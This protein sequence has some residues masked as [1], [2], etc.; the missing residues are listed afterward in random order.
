VSASPA[1]RLSAL[2]SAGLELCWLYTWADFLTF[3]FLDRPF[4][5]PHAL[6]AFFGGALIA[7]A[8]A[9]LT[10]R[11]LPRLG[12]HTA[13][14]LA[15]ALGTAYYFHG[16]D[17]G[18]SGFQWLSDL[19]SGP[20]PVVAG[21]YLALETIL[22]G[23]LYFV[24]R[25]WAKRENN[26]RSMANLFDLG[27]S[28]FVAMYLIRFF[29]ELKFGVQI[30]NPAG[31]RLPIAFFSFGLLGLAMA[32]TRG[33]AVQ[34]FKPRYKG[35]WSVLTFT[36]AA[37]LLGLGLVA[38]FFSGLT[39]AADV[40][41]EVVKTAARPLQPILIAVLRFMFGANR[42]EAAPQDPPSSVAIEDGISLSPPG[43]WEGTAAQI[44]G[45]IGAI[46]LA[47]LVAATGLYL[48][49][50]LLRHLLAEQGDPAP[51]LNV[52]D[53]FIRLLAR[54]LALVRGLFQ[55]PSPRPAEPLAAYLSLL[56]WGRRTGL[57]RR[58]SETPREYGRRLTRS[59]PGIETDLA[60]IVAALEITVYGGE[61]LDP[62]RIKHLRRSRRRLTHP[63]LWPKRLKTWF[64]GSGE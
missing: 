43:G 56:S 12:A 58:A 24:G 9:R 32:R 7:A 14:F 23:G 64:A 34:K 31:L 36:A 27:V 45:W 4:P 46:G 33:P 35:L 19:F 20:Q 30:E 6:A 39:S 22:A 42:M 59:F 52:R 21:F 18:F 44:V 3:A 2:T 41:Y 49:Y 61:S 17:Y 51:P 13:G 5:L 62:A 11:P 29:L 16:A 60:A 48:A 37:L 50:R 55:K 28:A 26:Y 25:K 53:F 8:V 63:D 15:A 47:L 38:F 1:G 57:P 10:R 40:G 54:F